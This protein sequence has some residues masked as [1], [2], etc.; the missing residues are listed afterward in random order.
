MAG[1]TTSRA[2][3]STSPNECGAEAM[4]AYHHAFKFCTVTTG[5]VCVCAISVRTVN[6]QRKIR[7]RSHG[8]SKRST[9]RSRDRYKDNM[10]SCLPRAK[11][12]HISKDGEHW[13]TRGLV[14]ISTEKSGCGQYAC[15]IGETQMHR[16]SSMW[17]K[18]GLHNL[19]FVVKRIKKRRS[20]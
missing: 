15:E 11:T 6:R 18:F 20:R 10:R 12:W 19:G 7:R 14:N 1:R 17:R 4:G 13:A 9:L 5:G 16:R 3:R 2:C 8:N